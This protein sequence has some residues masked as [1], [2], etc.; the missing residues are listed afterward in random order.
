MIFTVRDNSC[1][2]V[3]FLHLSVIIFTGGV[4]PLG[5]ALPLGRQSPPGRHL[6]LSRHSPRQTLPP[7]EQTPPLDRHTPPGQTP[8]T[9]PP[10]LG[11]YASYW[12]AFLSEHPFLLLFMDR[13]K[14]S[15]TP[16][17]GQL[18]SNDAG[19]YLF[20]SVHATPFRHFYRRVS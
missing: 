14:M 2:K 17:R 13:L 3:M 12:N 20:F 8:P 19:M 15:V 7:S 9:L 1:G 5:R 16:R 4:H 11:R 10:P 18:V 6:P